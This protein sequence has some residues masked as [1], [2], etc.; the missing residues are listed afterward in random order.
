MSAQE[1]YKY[2][3]AFSFLQEDEGVAR[4]GL[5]RFIDAGGRRH[6]ERFVACA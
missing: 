1:E 4:H 3:V 2:D 6:T 5:D